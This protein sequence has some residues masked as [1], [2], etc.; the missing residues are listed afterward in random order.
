MPEGPAPLT[1]ISH[2]PSLRESVTDT[3]RTAV[4]VGD[5]VEGELY[6]SLIHI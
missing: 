5:L 3:L 4:I 1:E 6:L 2:A